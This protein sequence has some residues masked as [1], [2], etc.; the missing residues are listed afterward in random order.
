MLANILMLRSSI[1]QQKT[2]ILSTCM[3]LKN[4]KSNCDLMYRA[5]IYTMSCTRIH[6][7]IRMLQTT[8][9]HNVLYRTHMYT[10]YHT[11]HICTAY[12]YTMY[13]IRHT[14]TP[15]TIQ[16]TYIHYVPY[17]PHTYVCTPC[18]IQ[19]TYV[20]TPCTVQT[21]YV[22]TPCTDHTPVVS[23]CRHSAH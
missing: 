4:R 20:C 3:P 22:C 10:M 16:T 14:R 7:Y 15:C 12:M 18:T 21:T 2:T 1:S 5:H 6:L 8:H 11:D 23:Q 19:T 17:R 9:V 13:C